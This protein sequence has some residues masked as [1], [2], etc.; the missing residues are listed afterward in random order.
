MSGSNWDDDDARWPLLMNHGLWFGS[1]CIQAQSSTLGTEVGTR[2]E[3]NQSI[4]PY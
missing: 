4:I 2:N 1:L 3:Y